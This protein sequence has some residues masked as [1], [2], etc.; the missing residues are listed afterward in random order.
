MG[1]LLA[2]GL[3]LLALLCEDA[4]A[5]SIVIQ[6]PE[7]MYRESRDVVFAIPVARS[8]QPKQ[9]TDPGYEGSVRETIL[10]R[11]MIRWKGQ[12]SS[13]RTFTTRR[14]FEVTDRTTCGRWLP[15]YRAKEPV[16]LFLEGSEPHQFFFSYDSDRSDLFEFLESTRSK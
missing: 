10:W 15:A 16:I 9:A 2:L 14:S 13:G 4:R 7:K 8:Y 6:P 1:R 12:Y 11:S 5:C 3:I